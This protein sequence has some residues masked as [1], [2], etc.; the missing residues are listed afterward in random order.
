MITRWCMGVIASTGWQVWS[1]PAGS[2]IGKSPGC[3]PEVGKPEG[4]VWSQEGVSAWVVDDP[5]ADLIGGRQALAALAEPL[6]DLCSE[7]LAALG[8]ALLVRR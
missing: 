5:Q 1:L 8:V 3:A 4:W 7:A 6:S 2:K